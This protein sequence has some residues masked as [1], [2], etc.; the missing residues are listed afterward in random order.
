M[1]IQI[2][3][4][5]EAD[6]PRAME[7]K[8]ALGW[9]QTPE[10]GRR[11]LQLSPKGSF[12]AMRGGRMVGTAIAQ[13][14]DRVCW[15]GM[16]MVA[17]GCRHQGVGRLMMN[18]C[19]A[20]SGEK[21]CSLV[22]LDAT[23]EAVGLYGSLGFRPEFLVGTAR[24]TIQEQCKRT[25]GQRTPA[26][27]GY[28]VR[29]VE[30]RDLEAI[31]SLEATAQGAVREALLMRLLE[32][33]PDR[34]FV[35]M[36]AGRRLEGFVLY[37]P[38]FHSIQIGPLIARGP[39]Q[40]ERLLQAVWTDLSASAGSV[41]ITLTVALNNTGMRR[42]L[43]RRGLSAEPRLTRMSRGRMRLQAREDMIYA[44]SGPEKG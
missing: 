32:Q 18:R 9:N 34:G 30:T 11:F 27:Q 19:L 7:L 38:G 16:V 13:V 36:G 31:V 40:A 35:C 42:I 14:F 41:E 12:K 5:Y 29:A 1:D 25:P 28:R 23:R 44:F 33:Y 24:G 4:L 17:E 6:I 20:F 43:N 37:R 39:E 3:P 21:D 22:V 15:I 10:D 26:E 2:L 8:N